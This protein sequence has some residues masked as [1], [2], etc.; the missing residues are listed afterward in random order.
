MAIVGQL[1]RHKKS[2]SIPNEEVASC[3]YNQHYLKEKYYA[4]STE[5]TAETAE[6]W[7]NAC[8]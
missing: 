3:G 6:H 7:H 4:N 1:L 2:V 8:I 5:R